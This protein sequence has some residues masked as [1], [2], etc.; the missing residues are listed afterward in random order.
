[1]HGR[2]RPCGH[3]VRAAPERQLPRGPADRRG[4]APMTATHCWVLS[5]LGR[6]RS[7]EAGAVALLVAL[8]TPVFV[9]FAALSVDVARWYVE[10]ERVQKAA[11]AA[12]LAGV[13]YMPQD[14]PRAKQT[15]LDIA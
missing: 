11:D 12:S 1:H 4:R 14:F 8:L 7:A 5:R 10:G 13:V 15:A 9:A 2:L 3:A 6:G